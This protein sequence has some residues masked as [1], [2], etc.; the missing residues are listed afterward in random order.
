[1]IRVLAILAAYRAFTSATPAMPPPPTEPPCGHPLMKQMFEQIFNEENG[2][3]VKTNCD[4]VPKATQLLKDYLNNNLQVSSPYEGKWCVK[5]AKRST[6]NAPQHAGDGVR[7]LFHMIDGSIDNLK[8]ADKSREIGCTTG[9]R[10]TNREANHKFESAL[11]CLIE[12]K[13]GESC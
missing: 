2:W 12:L 10:M 1:M 9:G 4:A 7:T 13:A 8:D 5:T 6:A 3:D 11:V